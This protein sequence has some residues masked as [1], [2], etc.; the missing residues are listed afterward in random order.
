MKELP[1]PDEEAI[2]G[3][4]PWP[5]N[6]FKRE[7]KMSPPPNLL[8]P[9]QRIPLSGKVGAGVFELNGQL[10]ASLVGNAVKN[11]ESGEV[12]VVPFPEN[13]FRSALPQIDQVI[14]GKVTKITSK[15]AAV[16]INAIEQEKPL[17]SQYLPEA[18]RG[19]IRYYHRF[20]Q[21]IDA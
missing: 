6:D 18:F 12:T 15:Y 14:I 1:P 16:D 19:T 21:F 20:S 3:K 8:L 13:S 5:K 11:E 17:K 10:Y 2:D 7:P 9:G 4:W